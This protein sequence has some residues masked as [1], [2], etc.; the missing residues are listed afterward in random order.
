MVTDDPSL[1]VGQCNTR[2][3]PAK[4]KHGCSETFACVSLNLKGGFICIFVLL[5]T[6][7]SL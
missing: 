7:R 4:A 6:Q 3:Q 1:V 5:S 2:N